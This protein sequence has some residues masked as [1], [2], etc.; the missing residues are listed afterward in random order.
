MSEMS[1]FNDI[2]KLQSAVACATD[3]LN[4]WRREWCLKETEGYSSDTALQQGIDSLWSFVTAKHNEEVRRLY[5]KIERL[6]MALSE[7]GY[8]DD[9]K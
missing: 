6:E 4:C 5:S 9:F 3:K 8:G 2:D 7:H 1:I